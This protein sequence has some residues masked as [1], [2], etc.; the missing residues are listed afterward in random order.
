MGSGRG[1]GAAA[2]AATG[3]GVGAALAGAD[4]T[5]AGAVRP[6]RVAAG[7]GAA[8]AG[9][10]GTALAELGGLAAALGGVERA[11]GAAGAVVDGEC[12]CGAAAAE[13]HLAEQ[14]GQA[15]SW[16]LRARPVRRVDRAPGAVAGV[17]CCIAG[18]TGG[19]SGRLPALE[20]RKIRLSGFV[21]SHLA[22]DIGIP[23]ER[24]LRRFAFV[25]HHVGAQEHEEVGLLASAILVAEKIAEPGDTAQE[26]QRTAAVV[27]TVLDQAAQH[28]G[29]AIIHHDFGF[30]R[31]LVGDEVARAGKHAAGSRRLP[32]RSPGGWSR[33]RRS[34]A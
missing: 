17:R 22:A 33:P 24:E 29:S 10:P 16:R 14:P 20:P 5:G 18:A 7:A 26:R 1:E 32:G 27:A 3:A 12:D 2:V 19:V 8:A 25:A 30:D 6:G 4:A 9:A 13:A 34:A 11:S 21:L 31:A 15:P 28:D 23:V